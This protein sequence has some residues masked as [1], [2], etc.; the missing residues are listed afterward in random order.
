[1]LFLRGTL[2]QGRQQICVMCPCSLVLLKRALK[3]E[4]GKDEL[5]LSCGGK[6]GLEWGGAQLA[7][8]LHSHHLRSPRGS[9]DS[10]RRLHFEG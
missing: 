8:W 10:Y 7:W 2:E 5:A 4:V 9:A 1:M 6:G 3:D